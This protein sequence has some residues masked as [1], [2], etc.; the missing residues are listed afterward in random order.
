VLC[1]RRLLREAAACCSDVPWLAC[2]A[3]AEVDTDCDG[4]PEGEDDCD[5]PADPEDDDTFAAFD[6]LEEELELNGWAITT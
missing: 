4:E 2:E 1:T 3:E 5:V 6:P